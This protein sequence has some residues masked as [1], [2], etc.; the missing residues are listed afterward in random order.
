MR[1]YC[2]RKSF[3]TEMKFNGNMAYILSISIVTKNIGIL[4]LHQVDANEAQHRY[5]AFWYVSLWFSSAIFGL[6]VPKIIH[7]SIHRA[8]YRIGILKCKVLV[9][10]MLTMMVVVV[11]VVIMVIWM[12]MINIFY[13]WLKL[14]TFKALISSSTTFIK[15]IIQVPWRLLWLGIDGANNFPFVLDFLKI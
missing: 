13:F 2:K 7:V 5:S 6:S 14:Y 1:N 15:G 8:V 10:L 4:H 11:L 3:R 12:V 9:I